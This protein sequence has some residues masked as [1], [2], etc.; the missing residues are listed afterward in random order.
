MTLNESEREELV[1]HRI[2]RAVLI[3]EEIQSH[4]DNGHLH[5]AINRIYYGMF[6][7][8]SALALKKGFVTSKHQQLIGWFNK[9]FVKTKIVD[10]KLSE[11]ILSAFDMRSH[12]DYDDYVE[13]SPDAVTAMFQDM[14]NFVSQIITII[15]SPAK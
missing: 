10:K 15:H 12:G 7:I 2:E 14:K 4:I 11:I 6:Y 9:E 3:I 5:T 13:F 8:L 1:N